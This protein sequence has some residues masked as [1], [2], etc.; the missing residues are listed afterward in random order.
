[1]AFPAFWDNFGAQFFF[2]Y[3]KG[4]WLATQSTPSPLNPPLGYVEHMDIRLLVMGRLK[5][6]VGL[7]SICQRADHSM[8]LFRSSCRVL[9]SSAEFI[10]RYI[11]VSS[12]KSLTVDRMP[13]AISF[14]YKR[15]S[16][17][18]KTEPCGTPDKTLRGVDWVLSVDWD[19]LSLARRQMLW[20]DE[21]VTRRDEAKAPTNERWRDDLRTD[22][23]HW[24]HC[25]GADRAVDMLREPRE[26]ISLKFK[27][28]AQSFW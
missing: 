26:K 20:R 27:M 17:G 28:S 8:S 24:G 16:V 9:W 21:L 10:W 15:N 22:F 5:H 2:C 3:S 18:P 14:M 12:A 7:N 11:I 13:L 1:M 23:W 25:L 19:Y 4:G 6:L